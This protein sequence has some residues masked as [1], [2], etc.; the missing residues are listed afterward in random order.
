M[1]RLAQLTGLHESDPTD[2]FC[3]YGIAMEHEKAG[4]HDDAVDWLRKTIE[5]DGSYC[6]AFYHMAKI[7]SDRGDDDEARLVLH[8]GMEAA[9]AGGDGHALEEMEELM[10]VLEAP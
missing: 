9:K 8:S 5:I 10:G 3:A 7:L 2:P 4:R 6:Y 1:D